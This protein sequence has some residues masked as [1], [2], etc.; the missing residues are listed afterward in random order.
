MKYAKSSKKSFKSRKSFKKNVKRNYS[1]PS[2]KFIKSVKKIIAKDV[3]TKTSI[4]TSNVTA[5]NQQIATTGDCLRLMPQIGQGIAENQRIANK[6]KLQ[7][8]NIRGVLTFT[9]GQTSA[10]NTRIGVRLMILR[11][12]KFG[13]WNAAATDFNTN[14][15]RLLEGI[16]TGFQ[17]TLQQYN[18]PY[19]PD[20]FSCVMD[21]RMYM[22]LSYSNV[23]T[24]T[25]D[26]VNTT[27]FVN[28]K[29]PYTKNKTVI[30]DEDTSTEPVNFPYFMVLG[31]TKLSG[32]LADSNLTTYLTFQYTATAH[33]EDA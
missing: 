31:Y 24:L 11:A 5:F 26:T 9:L 1:K 22:S 29:V 32:A 3:E 13:D 16:P 8:L 15:T 21:K 17:G 25:N 2:A 7:S 18:T 27:K 33:Y 12:K 6:I 14:Y 4:F 23:T 30:Y 20:Y 28:F 19:N 10:D